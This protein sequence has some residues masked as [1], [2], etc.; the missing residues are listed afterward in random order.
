MLM[1]KMVVLSCVGMAGQDCIAMRNLQL[2]TLTVAVCAG[3]QL[4]I[5]NLQKTPKG[6]E[7]SPADPRQG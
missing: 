7:G 2:T 4:V 1:H 6:Q 5:V 3:G